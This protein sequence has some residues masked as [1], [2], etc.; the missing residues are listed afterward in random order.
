MKTFLK[1]L[2]L[3][4]P[5]SVSAQILDEA[6]QMPLF[7]SCDNEKL[8]PNQR[9]ECSRRK[10]AEFVRQNIVYPPDALRDTVEG[11]VIV[12]FVVDSSGKTT[13]VK[14]V[15][16]VNVACGHEAVRVVKMFPEWAPAYNNGK[17]VAVRMRLPIK[18]NVKDLDDRYTKKSF[19]ITWG[20]LYTDGISRADLQSHLKEPMMVRDLFG[21]TYDIET[22]EVVLDRKGKL[23]R[24]KKAVTS[25]DKKHLKLLKRAKVGHTVAIIVAVQDG[26]GKHEAERIFT[27]DSEAQ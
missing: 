21:K 12:S 16:E 8:L 4:M 18:F 17:P 22:I 2:L 10:I 7:K 27:I 20:T 5:L 15:K 23:T 24:Y 26:T 13:N 1:L 3:A 14:S 11:T 9:E 6:E 25:L 19:V